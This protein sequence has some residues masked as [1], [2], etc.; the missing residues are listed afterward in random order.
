MLLLD[1]TDLSNYGLRERAQ[2]VGIIFADYYKYGPRIKGSQSVR[3]NVIE[4]S[5]QVHVL[6]AKTTNRPPLSPRYTGRAAVSRALAAYGHTTTTL[7]GL[8]GSTL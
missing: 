5:K 1:G 8:A 3:V 2:S 7:R 4:Q 6:L